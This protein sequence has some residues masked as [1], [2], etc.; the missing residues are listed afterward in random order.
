VAR[1]SRARSTAAA[2]SLSG[3]IVGQATKVTYCLIDYDSGK[4][5]LT[6][7]KTFFDCD[8]ELQGISVGF[9][10]EY[11]PTNKWIELERPTTRR[12]P[13]SSSHVRAAL[14]TA[15]SPGS[16]TRRAPAWRAAT[17]RIADAAQTRRP[18][19]PMC[20][21]PSKPSRR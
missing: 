20:T 17:R 3:P 16:R 10:D 4:N 13:S 11:H 7:A 12:G 18:M 5:G 6:S 1:P 8:A 21:P 14:E 19:K 2:G 9:G 15:T